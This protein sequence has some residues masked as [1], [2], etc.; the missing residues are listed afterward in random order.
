M[1]VMPWAGTALTVLLVALAVWVI[2]VRSTFAAVVGFVAYGIMLSLV[3]MRL[4]APDIALTEVAI[5]SGLTGVLMLGAGSRL[6]ATEGNENAHAPG[7][8]VRVV[9]A[10][11]CMAVTA[12]LA[13]TVLLL[14]EPAPSLAPLVAANLHH[15]ELGNP[16]TA[17]LIAFRATDTMLE[18][19]VL[20]LALVGAWSLAPDRLWGGFPG[21][22]HHAD[23]DGVL[24]Y[25][26][27]RLPPLGIIVTLY[28]FYAGSDGPGGEF[29]SATVLAAMW[30]L[31]MLAGV[32]HAPPTGELRVR[33][34]LVL[35]ST[36]FL[37]VGIVGMF[38]AGAFLAYPAGWAKVFI[39]AIEVPVTL[40]LAVALGMLMAGAPER[41][42]QA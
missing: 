3:W 22:R 37:V 18:V 16:V 19:I 27:R 2:V 15:T 32:T 21:L 25:A 29:Q 10:L 41:P 35:G 24:V 39:L 20:L 9:A 38:T 28:L 40:S 23:P 4:H 30:L 34:L 26:A 13:V 14:P 5:G 7:V 42:V 6:R 1:N 36:V 11:L 33:A 31:A 12:G 17:V 8:M